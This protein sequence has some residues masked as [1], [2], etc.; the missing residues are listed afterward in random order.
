MKKMLEILGSSFRLAMLELK[1][2]KLRTTLSLLGVTFGIFCI[3]GVLA[4]V[5]SLEQNVQ[6]DIKELGTNTIY[7][8][9][10][11]YS[12]GPD[13][14]WWKY[15]NR[16][17]PKFDEMKELKA[18]STV[19]K[20]I[21]FTL[22]NQANLEHG[23]EML[24][25]VGIYGIT[26]GF[27]EIQPFEMMAGRYFS[28]MELEQG[29]TNAVI[30]YE[31]AEKLFG[32]ADKAI[33]EEVKIKNKKAKIIGVIKKQGKSMIGGWEFDQCLLMTYPYYRLVFEEKWSNPNIMV[34]G[35]DK[36]SVEAMRGELKGTMRN[37]R[38]LGP[39]DEDDFSLNSVSDFSKAVSGFFGSVTLGGWFIGLLSLIVGAF[40]IANIM[41]VTV[42]ERTP[43]IGLKKAIGAKKGTI[44]AEFLLESAFICLLGG[45]IGLILVFILTFF[46][47]KAFEFPVFISLDILSLAIGICV[48]IGIL[49][50]IIPASIAARMDPV[51]AIRSK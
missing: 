2:N 11:D 15:V 51:V 39:R 22:N 6:N 34:Q 7:I 20:N 41:F 35:Q 9:K 12:G 13:Y 4:T 21:A 30:G 49:A 40:S 37:L 42:R 24:T 5:N 17:T 48:G 47:T 28:Q 31:N 14:P 25:N 10:W 26:L 19:I 29:T 38:R 44:L 16:P 46:L 45:A 32:K 18:R 50:G 8:D 23:N 33:G 3:I 36:M 27:I 43:I 1:N